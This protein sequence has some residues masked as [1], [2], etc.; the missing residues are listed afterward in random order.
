[1]RS[2]ISIRNFSKKYGENVVLENIDADIRRGEV[3]SIIGPSGTGKSTLLRALNMLDPP[4][5]GDFG[6][7][8]IRHVTLQKIVAHDFR[9][10][11]RISSNYF[12]KSSRHSKCMAYWYVQ[13]IK[14]AKEQS[15]TFLP[16]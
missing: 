6:L 15:G 2:I 8:I 4:S 10:V 1:M 5:G 7:S 12:L 9:Y 14:F 13:F 3:I 11:P 16:G